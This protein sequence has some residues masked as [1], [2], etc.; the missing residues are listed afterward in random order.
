MKEKNRT[1]SAEQ[2]AVLAQCLDRLP[3]SLPLDKGRFAR[4]LEEAWSCS[5][6]DL[7]VILSRFLWVVDPGRPETEGIRLFAHEPT[8]SEAALTRAVLHPRDI[9]LEIIRKRTVLDAAFL[10]RVYDEIYSKGNPEDYGQIADLTEERILQEMKWWLTDLKFPE[11]YLKNTPAQLMARQIMLNRSYELSGL[12]S[13]TYAQM[14][15]S[16]TSSDGT[17][18]HWVHRRRSLEVEEEIER[19]YY[20]G[21]RLLNVAVYAPVPDLLLY[22]VYRSPDPRQGE[23]IA[24]IAPPSFLSITDPGAQERYEA[25]RLQVLASGQ[26]VIAH[27]RKPETGETRVMIGFPRGRINHFQANISRVMAR[28]GIECTRKYTATFGGSRPVIVATLYARQDFPADLPRQLVEV[29]LYPPGQIGAMVERGAI[30]PAEAN[31]MNAVVPF[32]H[33]FI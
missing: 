9:V 14:K 27:S 25:V 15:V 23:R 11:Y 33:Q 19:E 31:L 21:G 26:I 29:S 2:R 24:E 32:V 6:L 10:S 17:S 16:S 30:T 7:R 4:A 1:L 12:D 13:E 3:D 5:C 22:V 18:V 28:N 8:L 20:A